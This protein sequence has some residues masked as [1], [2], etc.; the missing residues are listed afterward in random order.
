MDSLVSTFHLDV[1]LLIAQVVNFGIVFLVLYFFAFKPLLKVMGDRST[2][3]EKSLRDADE[4]EKKLS[5]A[6]VEK[7]E[8][9]AAARKA[10][11]AVLA[12]AKESGEVKKQEL[13]AKAKEEI[14]K[15]IALEKE[16]MANEKTDAMDEIK[17]EVASLV[18]ASLEKFLGEKIDS[19]ADMDLIKKIVK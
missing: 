11:Q 7:D 3:I 2:K 6:K 10:A 17:G 12:E 9:I 18:A 16:K 8:I 13:V 14:A 5:E 4:I 15:V 19:K 1:K